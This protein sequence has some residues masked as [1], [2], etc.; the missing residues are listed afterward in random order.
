MVKVGKEG[1]LQT[2]RLFVVNPNLE[3][4]LSHGHQTTSTNLRGLWTNAGHC[5]RR[6]QN[7][8]KNPLLQRW[9]PSLSY[10]TTVR[11]LNDNKNNF[12]LIISAVISG[13]YRQWKIGGISV[14]TYRSEL[15]Q[16]QN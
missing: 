8:K 2:S 10:H 9:H 15:G 1:T 3:A 11:I 4:T 6:D 5:H 13:T 7:G 14:H 12:D 16:A